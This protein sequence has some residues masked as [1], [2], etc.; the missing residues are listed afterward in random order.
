MIG[1]RRD[2]ADVV[3]WVHRDLRGE[4]IVVAG[5]AHTFALPLVD[6]VSG[7]FEMPLDCPLT[8][9]ELRIATSI[10]TVRLAGRL[11]CTSHGNRASAGQRR[12]A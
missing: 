11:W 9:R 8:A 7:D 3:V 12:A 5:D 4:A 10:V 2:G 6:L 1:L